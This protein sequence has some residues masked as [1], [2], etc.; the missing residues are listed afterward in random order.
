MPPAL[1]KHALTLADSGRRLVYTYETTSGQSGITEL[2]DDLH[3]AG[4]RIKD[5][6][7][8]E[9]SLEDIFVGLVRQGR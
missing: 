7:T 8:T 6:H 5:L 1:T 2:I 9:T 3:L 4:L